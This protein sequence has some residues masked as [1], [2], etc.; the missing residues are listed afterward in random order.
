MAA[1]A[2]GAGR[3]QVPEITDRMV[4]SGQ[5][6]LAA[7]PMPGAGSLPG[8]SPDTLDLTFWQS[9]QNSRNATDYEEYLRQF[10]QG[11]FAVPARN[12]LAEMRAAPPS[13]QAA[14]PVLAPARPTPSVA[15]AGSGYP[16]G[17]GQ[18][19][20]DCGDCPEMVVIPAGRF[21]MGSPASEPGRFDWEGPQR[22]VFLRSSLAVGKFEVT[23][24]EWDACVA[25][26]GCSH[27]PADEGWGRGRQPV[28]NVSWNDAQ[29]YVRWL[30]GRTG[31]G[32]RLLT[33]A[34]WSM[35]HG[36]GR[37]RPIVL[38][39]TSA[40]RRRITATAGW[41]GRRLLATMG[42]M[43]GSFTTCMGMCGSGWRIVGLA[44]TRA[45]RQTGPERSQPVIVLR[46]CF[47]AVRGAARLRSSAPHI[48]TGS[49]LVS[50]TSTSASVLPGR[51]A[52]RALASPRSKPFMDA[53][54]D[55]SQGR[56]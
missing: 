23:F 20:R 9:I 11:R 55:E 48:A 10:P 8:L 32:Y 56:C 2:H 19:F 46:V 13:Q 53:A 17:V 40:R 31:R 7:M 25:G 27:R 28:M 35:R 33:E 39:R 5:L 4:G 26:G 44:A 16:V 34:E 49:L 45:R 42:R 30:S 52:S 38:V 21:T 47:A 15:P 1:A 36:R 51:P 3:R 12:R 37:R 54:G 24:G 29:Q 6:L 50:G 22:E 43:G 18:S 14:L 41:V